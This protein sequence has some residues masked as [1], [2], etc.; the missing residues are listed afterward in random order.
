[1][2][3]I[4]ILTAAAL[5][6]G[7][8]GRLPDPA[9]HRRG[10]GRAVPDPRL[11]HALGALGAFGAMA[12]AVGRFGATTL[13][14]LA[15]LVI[16]YW[17]TPRCS[18]SWW[19]S[20][21]SR[22]SMGLSIFAILRLIRDELL[23]VLGTASSEVV[24][25]RLMEKLEKAGLRRVDRRASWCRAATASTSTAPRSTWRSPSPSSPRPPTRRSTSGSRPACWRSCSSP[26]RVAPPWR[27]ALHQARGDA[28]IGALAAS[29]RAG[30]A[31][32]RRPADGDLHA[33]TN[34]VGNVVATFYIARWR[35]PSTS[36][37]GR[38]SRSRWRRAG[39]RSRPRRHTRSRRLSPP[40]RRP[41]IKARRVSALC[42]FLDHAGAGPGAPRYQPPT[43]ARPGATVPG[44]ARRC[45][46]HRMPMQMVEVSG[47]RFD[48]SGHELAPA[49]PRARRLRRSGS[50][51]RS[52]GAPAT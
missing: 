39:S 15:K 26:R 35:A 22:S 37:S 43:Q 24:L 12:A 7:G 19:C 2:L 29:Q 31:V 6:V 25:P 32:R 49:P 18:S 11:H 9:R 14:Y 51:P 5:S 4:S 21:A 52:R 30:P 23:V 27:A 10:A 28:A 47:G 8:A 41:R 50:L 40:P 13:V 36:R 46:L 16:L 38:P 44:S 34:V 33:L 48:R 3:L 1:M 17:L 42:R 45:G 20:A